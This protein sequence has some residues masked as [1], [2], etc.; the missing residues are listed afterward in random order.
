MKPSIKNNTTCKR[1]DPV[2]TSKRS[3]GKSQKKL[4]PLKEKPNKSQS[5][6]KKTLSIVEQAELLLNS[7]IDNALGCTGEVAVRFNHYN[8]SFPVH[9]GVLRWSS[10]DEE[11]CLSFVYKGNFKRELHIA[12]PPDNDN[13]AS[14]LDWPKATRDELGFYFINI[15]CN[16]FVFNLTSIFPY[17]HLYHM[18][19]MMLGYM[20]Y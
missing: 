2:K 16:G 18:I 8:K 11:Y 9:N 1:K 3:V 19:Y 15:D 12:P 14:K 13:Y 5:V 20:S 17:I 4:V 7:H 10:I 6:P